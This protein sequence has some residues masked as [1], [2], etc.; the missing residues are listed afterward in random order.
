MYSVKTKKVGGKSYRTIKKFKNYDKAYAYIGDTL[1]I[2]D[3]LH[4]SYSTKYLMDGYDKKRIF[5]YG[6]NFLRRKNI[7]FKI[8]MN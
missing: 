1:Q 2:K 3:T 8:V 5:P 4:W 7:C 6:D